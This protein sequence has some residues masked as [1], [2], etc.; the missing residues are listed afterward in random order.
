MVDFAK[1]I[2]TFSSKILEQA[3]KKVST[4]LSEKLSPIV[5]EEIMKSYDT[6]LVGA[7]G[8]IGSK[9]PTAPSNLRSIFQSYLENQA[10]NALSVTK[11]GISFRL[12][13]A[14]DIGFPSGPPKD[15]SSKLKL[16]FF[17]IEGMIGDLVFI[18]RETYKVFNPNNQNSSLG[19]FGEGFLLSGNAYRKK[20]QTLLQRKS[21]NPNT[22]I[23]PDFEAVKHPLSGAGPNDI[24]RDALPRIRKRINILL[25]NVVKDL[26]K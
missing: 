18:D 24:F 14:R 3:Q 2:R 5:V 8:S 15:S 11:E 22:K 21:V 23:L 1:L 16:I 20:Q 6:M 4:V 17:Y 13:N 12:I 26:I 7:E 9:D 10:S 19:R 25:R